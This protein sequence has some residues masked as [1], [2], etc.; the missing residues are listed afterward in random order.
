M[1]VGQN[2]PAV[3][4]GAAI[5]GRG[6]KNVLNVTTNTLVKGSP[7]RVATVIVNTAGSTAGAVYDA[8]SVAS[9]TTATAASKLVAT[10]PNTVG[11]Y[12]MDFPCLT[13]VVVEPGT[14]QVVSVSY[15]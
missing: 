13:G 11:I 7:G 4:N 15:N 2:Q 9:I 14:G 6:I 3:I 8:S 5:T 10:I 1:A 12:P